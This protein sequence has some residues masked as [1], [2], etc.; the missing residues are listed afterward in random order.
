MSWIRMRINVNYRSGP[1]LAELRRRN[2][3]LDLNQR[4]GSD[5]DPSKK[6]PGSATLQSGGG[7]R[8]KGFASHK[9]N[10]RL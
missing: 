8:E 10:F 4:Q 1:L 6:K 3:S 7:R 2:V 5:P 9:C